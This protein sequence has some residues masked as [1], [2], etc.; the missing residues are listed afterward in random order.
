MSKHHRGRDDR[1]QG[2]GRGGRQRQDSGARGDRESPGWRQAQGG[3]QGSGGYGGFGDGERRGDREEWGDQG[4]YRSEDEYRD[5]QRRP[6]QFDQRGGFGGGSDRPYGSSVYGGQTGRGFQQ[7]P[8]GG[9]GGS[10]MSSSGRG[11]FTGKG[12]KGYKRSDDRIKEDVCECLTEHGD[13]DAS[14]LDVQVREG[15]VTLS[16]TVS[17]RR[18]KRMVEDAVE[19]R[20][21]VGHVQNNIRVKNGS[22][23]RPGASD[24]TGYSGDANRGGK[25]KQQ[26]NRQ[27][28]PSRAGS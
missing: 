8:S 13:I 10:D 22:A 2:E 23:D 4:R 27:F 15:E 1:R 7:E 18:Q 25:T 5:D 11:P 26:Q 12:P 20:M 16:G 21:G 24:E 14:D 17:D 3:Q 28:E 6:Q 19:Q 9:R